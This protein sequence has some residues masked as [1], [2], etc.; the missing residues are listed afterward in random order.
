[1]HLVLAAN[2]DE[3]RQPINA[4]AETV[5]PEMLKHIYLYK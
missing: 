3:L 1:M 4:A 2:K 5:I